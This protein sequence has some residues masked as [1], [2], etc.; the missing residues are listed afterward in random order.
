MSNFT[1][2]VENAAKLAI[3]YKYGGIFL[4]LRHTLLKPLR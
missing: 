2:H 1:F 4:D 3:M